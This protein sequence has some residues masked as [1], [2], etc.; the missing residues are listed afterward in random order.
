LSRLAFAPMSYGRPGYGLPETRLVNMFVDPSPAGP[1]LSAHLQRPGLASAYSLGTSGIR[2]LFREDGVFGGDLFA[3]AGMTLYRSATS[4]G[5][6]ALGADARFAAS[7]TQMVIVAGGLAYCYDGSTLAQITVPDEDGVEQGVSDV[8]VIGSRF[9]FQVV[10]S[11]R[12]YFSALDDATSID[13]LAFATADAAPDA[14]V[15]LGIIGAQ[16][17]VFGRKTVEFW[18]QTGDQDAPLVRMQGAE[19]RRGCIAKRSIIYADNRLW[20]VGDDLKVYVTGAPDLVSTHAIDQRLRLCTTPSAITA[21][22]VSWDGHE[23]IAW[24][25]PGQGTFA[26]H[27]ES[28]QWAEWTSY[29][30]TTFRCGTAQMVDGT[31]Y[32]GD[33]LSGTI[34]TLA[35]VFTD[36]GEAIEFIATCVAPAGAI[37]SLELECAAGV[38]L[39]DGST[40]YVEMRES[41]DNGRTWSDWDAR[42]LGLIGEY[43]AR[44]RWNRLGRSDNDRHFEFRTTSPVRATYAAAR[45]NEPR[46]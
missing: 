33:T 40:P 36:D 32:L 44:P 14:S 2:G 15:G 18:R 6:V 34:F 10:G 27:V 43:D 23:F 8:I 39:E 1:A 17:V 4:I 31:A 30:R 9:Y 42:S 5:T 12:W 21:F 7:Y 19:Y 41:S 37:K 22:T 13:G 38:G 35:D 29:G 46:P 25:I 28:R 16:V 11:D 24:T 45:V 20:W 26:Y 3:V